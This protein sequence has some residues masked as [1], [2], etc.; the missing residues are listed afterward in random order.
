MQQ[1]TL[2]DS[3]FDTTQATLSKRSSLGTLAPDHSMNQVPTADS[4]ARA[5]SQ[6]HPATSMLPIEHPDYPAQPTTENSNKKTKNSAHPENVR[7]ITLA[8]QVIAYRFKRSSRRT[9]GLT[10]NEDGLSVSAPR[11]ASYKN[12]DAL[13]TEKQ[14]WIFN[15]L[16]EVREQQARAITPPITW[17]NGASLPYLGKNITLHFSPMTHIKSA[18]PT[19]SK[20]G[21]VLCLCLPQDAGTQQIKDRV[22]SWIKKQALV[23]FTERLD[24]Y[25]K[26]LGVKYTRLSLSSATTR[27]GSCN[28]EGHIRLNWRLLHFSPTIIDYVVA[29]EL[30]HLKEMNH[31]ARF[32]DTVASIFPEYDNVREHLN[33]QP[34]PNL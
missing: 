9:I 4:A 31:S 34:V 24:Y 29:H 16:V 33:R 7:H 25:A 8:G 15:K 20:D 11:W 30:S 1:L 14:K 10:I 17:E 21:S 22:Q 27:W 19:L 32:W 2:F 5:D 12:I 26:K 13:L 6:M 28:N 18:T 23:F 3:M